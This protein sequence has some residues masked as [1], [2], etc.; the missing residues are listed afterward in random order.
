MEKF[1]IFAISIVLSVAFFVSAQAL[2]KGSPE[3]WVVYYGEA[4]P[5]ERFMDYKVI[6]F[7]SQNHPPLRP[8]MNRGKTLLGYLSIGEAENYRRDFK[9]IQNMG[10]LLEENPDWP[11]HYIVDVRNKQWV[12]YLIEVKIPEIL[13]KNFDGLMLDTLDSALYLWEKD[14]EKYAGMDEA[15]IGLLA[16]IRKHYPRIKIMVN[17]GFHILPEIAPYIDMSLAESI[18]VNFHT[19]SN[20]PQYFDEAVTQEYVDIIKQAQ[21]ENPKLR[22]YSLDYWPP[23]NVEEVKNIYKKQRARGYV[24]YVTTIDLMQENKEPK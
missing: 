15:A 19:N 2:E 1:V 20:E 11:G 24:P 23:S 12:K 3:K 6:A 4:L 5:A 14:K 22:V 16:T 10:A 9:K 17:R 7:D 13:H 8:L 21:G 18:M